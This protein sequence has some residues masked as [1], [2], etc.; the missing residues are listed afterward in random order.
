MEQLGIHVFDPIHF[1]TDVARKSTAGRA[2]IQSRTNRIALEYKSLVA[3]IM[4]YKLRNH[5]PHRQSLSQFG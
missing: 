3:K 4:A 2:I 5:G 1:S